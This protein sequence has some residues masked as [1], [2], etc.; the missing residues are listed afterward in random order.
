MELKT[1]LLVFYSG[2]HE[3]SVSHILVYKRPRYF[4]SLSHPL[5]PQLCPQVCSYICVAIPSIQIG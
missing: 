5:L 3:L 1:E 2:F 4:L